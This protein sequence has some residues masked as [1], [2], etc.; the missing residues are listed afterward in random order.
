M[1]S[2]NTFCKTNIEIIL[3]R[4]HESAH[5]HPTAQQRKLA[6]YRWSVHQ[7]ISPLLFRNTSS[8]FS[9]RHFWQYLSCRPLSRLTPMRTRKT[10]TFR[11]WHRPNT[12]IDPNSL[13]V[14]LPPRASPPQRL[15]LIINT[16]ITCQQACAKNQIQP[17]R[18]F[19]NNL[20]SH[21]L[22]SC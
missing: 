10:F 1:L 6:I 11:S 14:R 18:R 7:T 15:V 4:L 16:R 8:L 5:A 22:W 20:Q 2:P 3:L 21:F 9:V 17:C 12:L 13:P 19:T